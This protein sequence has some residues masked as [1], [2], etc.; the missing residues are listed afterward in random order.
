M[1]DI[2]SWLW[3]HT[4]KVHTSAA[5]DHYGVWFDTYGPTIK[6]DGALGVGD[7][8]KAQRR[9]LRGAFSQDAVNRMEPAVTDI[10]SK[11]G[12][13]LS[14][15]IDEGE[16][17][18]NMHD[19]ATKMMLDAFG[20]VALNHEFKVLEGGAAEIRQTWR[21]Q[22]NTHIES[23]GHMEHGAVKTTIKPVAQAIIAAAESSQ[24]VSESTGK[25]NDLLSM[26]LRSGDMPREQL[27]DDRALLT[28]QWVADIYA[29]A[30]NFSGYAL[31]D[32][33]LPL[34]FPITT[35]DGRRVS[36][37]AIRKA[38]GDGAQWRPERWLEGEKLRAKRDSS[39]G[40]SNM[41]NTKYIHLPILIR[42]NSPFASKAL[43]ELKVIMAA[44]IKRFSFELPSEGFDI[45]GKFSS[46]LP[47]RQGG[48]GERR[49]FVSGVEGL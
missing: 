32:D 37:I 7:L 39:A 38:E 41:V 13:I 17:V 19:M 40:W 35:P 15:M 22:G 21:G 47:I 11:M 6:L 48:G 5:G 1:A 10:A 8:H 12:S 3:G 18:I 9:Q 28:R 29:H 36:E 30:K 27:I 45:Q 42:K 33:F 44:L 24:A 20:C 43:L 16:D 34:R 25:D 14:A 46:P 2:P 26:F 49:V 4:R 23:G 31:N